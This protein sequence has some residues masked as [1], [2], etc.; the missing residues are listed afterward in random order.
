MKSKKDIILTVRADIS[1]FLSFF[2]CCK[3]EKLSSRTHH[4]CSPKIWTKVLVYFLVPLSLPS[5][6][7]FLLI[8]FS[9]GWFRAVGNHDLPSVREYLQ[10][11]KQASKQANK[12]NKQTNQIIQ[13]FFTENF[14]VSRC[15]HAR[16]TNWYP[17]SLFYSFYFIFN[18]SFQ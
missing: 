1:F 16:S 15:C 7:F 8:F 6:L 10:V 12:Q 13:F 3:L 14:I 17:L 18:F 11:N 2:L 4:F 9:D 5:L